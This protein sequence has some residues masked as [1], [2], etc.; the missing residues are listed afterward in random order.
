MVGA[1]LTAM[2]LEQGQREPRQLA[3]PL[4]KFDGTYLVSMH[5][6]T[7]GKSQVFVSINGMEMEVATIEFTDPRNLGSFLAELPEEDGEPL[8][9]A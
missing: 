9:S 2:L 8:V 7:V 6:Q 4:D 5:Q 1:T 3:N